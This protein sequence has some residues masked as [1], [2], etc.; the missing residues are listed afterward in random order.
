M[1]AYSD[2]ALILL[3]TDVV[4]EPNQRKRRFQFKA[5]WTN[6]EVC[7]RIITTTWRLNSDKVGLP[8]VMDWIKACSEKLT[9]WNKFTF[10]SVQKRIREAQQRL[11]QLKHL[12]PLCLR[13]KNHKSIR[14][15][16]FK[17]MEWEEMIWQQRLRVLWLSEG[18]RNTCYF[19]N[20]AS[21]RKKTNHIS[22]I[23]N[24]AG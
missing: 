10:G 7:R 16:V 12:D 24:S 1:T 4:P 17:W 5:M 2:H 23:Q 9:V 20:K 14:N 15:E 8:S 18:D 13:P 21:Q 22:N 11:D 19:H 3:F 6:T